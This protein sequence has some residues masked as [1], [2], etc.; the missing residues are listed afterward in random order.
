MFIYTN[1]HYMYIAVLFSITV[2]EVMLSVPHDIICMV[3]VFNHN[4]PSMC[5]TGKYMDLCMVLK[6]AM[7]QVVV[8]HVRHEYEFASPQ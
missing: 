4:N 2:Q 1:V 6:H 3:H 5:T 7:L 8:R